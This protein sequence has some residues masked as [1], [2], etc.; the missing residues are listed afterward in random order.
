[1]KNY[2]VPCILIGGEAYLPMSPSSQSPLS[3]EGLKPAKGISY[4]SDD[5]SDFPKRAYS[6][7]SRPTPKPSY[8]YHQQTEMLHRKTLDGSKS[9]SAPHLIVQKHRNVHMDSY[10]ASP[11]SQS[12]KSDDADSFMEMDFYRPRTASDSYGCRPRSSS[13]GKQIFQGHRP[14]SSSYGQ[15][16]KG[17]I[18]KLAAGLRTDSLDSMR[19]QNMHSK[20]RSQESLG[21]MSTS[22]RNSSS[23]SLKKLS[24]DMHG[25][26]NLQPSDYID[27]GFDK[28]K[29][30]SPN[31]AGMKSPQADPS[32]YV[33]MTLGTSTPKSSSRGVSPSS[34]THSLGSSPAS[35]GHGHNE[36]SHNATKVIKASG[37]PVQKPG[38]KSPQLGTVP[39][40]NQLK[41]LT[42][43]LK[44]TDKRSPSSSGKESEDESYVP[45]QPSFASPKVTEDL[46][47]RSHTSTPDYNT[48]SRQNLK[49]QHGY[50]KSYDSA[51]K[52]PEAFAT[53]FDIKSKSK[54]AEKT[55]PKSDDEGKSEK[56]SKSKS[57]TDKDRR[58]SLKEGQKAEAFKDKDMKGKSLSRSD[59][60]GNN[61]VELVSKGKSPTLDRKMDCI[62]DDDLFSNKIFQQ[63]TT[64]EKS[65]SPA[66]TDGES[67]A[68]DSAYLEYDPSIS[69]KE[70]CFRTETMTLNKSPSSDKKFE[71]RKS[72][73][74][75]YCEIDPPSVTLSNKKEE[76]DYIEADPAPLKQ[77]LKD[78]PSRGKKNVEP[79]DFCYIDFDPAT[80]MTEKIKS[81]SEEKIRAPQRVQSFISMEGLDTK[82][83]KSAAD[84]GNES[85]VKASQVSKQCSD[86]DTSDKGRKMER[87][88]STSSMKNSAMK[89]EGEKC[90]GGSSCKNVVKQKVDNSKDSS[91]GSAASNVGQGHETG[92][93]SKV[94]G[95]S[96]KEAVIDSKNSQKVKTDVEKASSKDN[97]GSVK[98][99]NVDNKKL[100]IKSTGT[101]KPDTDMVQDEGYCLLDYEKAP[102]TVPVRSHHRSGSSSSSS[103]DR[104]RRVE[105]TS[106]EDET[107]VTDTPL[108]NIS[109]GVD[110]SLP[111]PEPGI[112]YI[113]DDMEPSAASTNAVNVSSPLK[114]PLA[115]RRSS[116][117]VGKDPGPG[118][119]SLVQNQSDLQKSLPS[120]KLCNNGQGNIS[121]F[122]R[123]TSVPVAP[124]KS[125]RTSGEIQTTGRCRTPS[126][127]AAMASGAKVNNGNNATAI[128]PKCS[129][130]AN[131][132][133]A[134]Q[135]LHKQK[136][137]PC[138]MLPVNVDK[139]PKSV[140]SPQD[141][142]QSRHSFTDLSQ[143]EEM[144]F[145]GNG[146]SQGSQAK[147]NSQQTLSDNST[148][149]TNNNSNELHYADLDLKNSSENVDDKSPRIKRRHPS[150]MDDLTQGSVP[151]AQIDYIKTESMKQ[152]NEKDVKFTLQ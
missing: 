7:G 18:S 143:Y 132:L 79:D 55:K 144:S 87:K 82:E 123:Q 119:Q 12:V 134:A 19:S 92:Q 148:S 100:V 149:N 91:S 101:V 122:S 110:Q 52:S 146:L 44:M 35:I 31:V 84:A 32:G 72:L 77:L 54:K 139:S 130:Q 51:M 46:M 135:E 62:P 126:G 105:S 34:S 129:A 88:S 37:K 45:F 108:G 75:E 38:Y 8:R 98:I 49:V 96:N 24:E 6:V 147:S 86:T 3:S 17:N 74:R 116:P 151:Y 25:K 56:S 60:S 26:K 142:G 36:K 125:P 118:L 43:R 68:N 90:S 33:D 40:D 137:M 14:R 57:K 127:P 50:S 140:D 59:S 22:S 128:L 106:T 111:V 63:T 113:T 1:M 97:V 95:Q 121:G 136:S 20:Q 99:C 41:V 112:C 23:D 83:T 138:M 124:T 145:P 71:Q 2:F 16:S 115:A 93:M 117:S 107:P 30:P 102:P 39:T 15:G 150:S 48:K 29:T 94:K 109:E 66:E 85:D 5:Y 78:S 53:G 11:L 47:T 4:L 65:P 70:Q 104:G 120:R 81:M 152:A 73:S 64:H 61:L 103:S 58:K 141:I 114:Q 21:K 27:M 80:D 10:P 42:S 13:F 89:T 131:V 28:R 76:S 9:S 69:Y 67:K 133:D